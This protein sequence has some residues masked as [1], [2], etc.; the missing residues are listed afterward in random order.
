MFLKE[1]R[2]NLNYVKEFLIARKD[3]ITTSALMIWLLQG[4]N[5]GQF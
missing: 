3:N 5:N 4:V 1:I 2:M